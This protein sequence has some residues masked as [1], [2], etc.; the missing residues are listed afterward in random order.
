MHNDYRFTHGT[1]NSQRDGP[2]IS[3]IARGNQGSVECWN[4]RRWALD[5]L[6]YGYRYKRR[7]SANDITVSRRLLKLYHKQSDQWLDSW[8]L[9]ALVDSIYKLDTRKTT[10]V[11]QFIGLLNWDI[12]FWVLLF[13]IICCSTAER[14]TGGAGALYCA[15]A[16]AFSARYQS[17]YIQ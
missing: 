12:S 15:D 5:L 6:V 10:F 8:S 17:N 13:S 11:S 4:S 3:G 2:S 1:V 16:P 7:E 14:D 9:L